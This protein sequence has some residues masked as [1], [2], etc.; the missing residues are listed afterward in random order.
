P[1]RPVRAPRTRATRGPISQPEAPPGIASW[2]LGYRPGLDGLRAIAVSLVVASHLAIPHAAGGGI[3]V[4]IFFVLSGF[5][6]TALLLQE[7]VRDRHVAYLDFY[8]RRALR[9]LP[10]LAVLLPI[11]AVVANLAPTIDR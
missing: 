11:V 2:R 6:I 7:R 9:L 10:A 1:A 8:Q 5:L 3:G 4:D